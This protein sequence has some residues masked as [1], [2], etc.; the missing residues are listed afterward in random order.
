MLNIAV[1]NESRTLK[2]CVMMK[3]YLSFLNY[4]ITTSF[5]IALKVCP[6]GRKRI[7]LF[8]EVFQISPCNF[9]CEHEEK[10]SPI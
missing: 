4:F 9:V 6:S 2:V 7:F 5:P 8:M 10:N 3:T 1:E